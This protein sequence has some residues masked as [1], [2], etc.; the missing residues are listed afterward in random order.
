MSVSYLTGNAGTGKS[1]VVREIKKR[2]RTLLLA[3]TG[4]AALNIGGQT[5]HRFFKFGRSL[6]FKAG[7]R[8]IEAIIRGTDIIIIDEVSMVRADLMDAIDK[9]LRI[10]TK[11]LDVP[12]GGKDILLV[13]DMGQL[14]PVVTADEA[15]T[16]SEN[17][18]SPFWFSA[19]VFTGRNSLDTFEPCRYEIFSLSKIFRQSDPVW[20]DALNKVRR[21]DVSGLDV[22]NTRV[23]EK[24]SDAIILTFT[25]READSSNQVGLD[26][27]AGEPKEFYAEKDGEWKDSEMPVAETITLKV[28]ARVI[29]IA[30]V[31]DP[32]GINVMNG[33][34]GTVESLEPLIVQLD[35]GRKWFVQ[36]YTWERRITGVNVETGEPKEMSDGYYTQIPLRLAWAITVHKSQ[37]QTYAKAHLSAGRKAFDHGQVYVALSRVKSLAG[38][39]LSRKLT[40]DDIIIDPVISAFE[41]LSAMEKIA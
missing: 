33:E 21:G 31:Y 12:F 36:P 22:V 6:S 39:S 35:N 32:A 14:P 34:M 16:F 10:I 29:C 26:A 1:V 15:R 20:I 2:K 40:A 19:H 41:M 25:N 17:Y 8:E 28:G 13:G 38:L 24:P 23:T 4:L 30:N 9:A 37:G 5:I 7:N 11:K 18:E 3:P 27:L